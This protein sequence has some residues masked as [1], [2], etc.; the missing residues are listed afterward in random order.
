[1][2]KNFSKVLSFSL[3]NQVG[4]KGYKVVT[5]IVGILFF[6][7]P[8]VIMLLVAYNQNKDKSLDSCGAERIYVVSQTA[9]DDTFWFSLK[10][11]P[12]GLYKSVRYISCSWMAHHVA[13]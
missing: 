2:F 6:A 3:K 8:L 13:K 7:L 12:E 4:T 11:L 1:M 5:S 9:V 10:E